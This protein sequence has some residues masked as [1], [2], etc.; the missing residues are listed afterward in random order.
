MFRLKFQIFKFSPENNRNTLYHASAYFF[1]YKSLRHKSSIQTFSH[2]LES[3]WGHFFNPFRK[4]I[5]WNI[6]TSKE[7]IQ[8]CSPA[9]LINPLVL[10]L[11]SP[12]TW[13]RPLHFLNRST[14]HTLEKWKAGFLTVYICYLKILKFWFNYNNFW[15]FAIIEVQL[16]LF[17][18]SSTSNTRDILHDWC[19]H[20]GSSTSKLTFISENPKIFSIF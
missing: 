8:D 7:F 20:G 10:S 13:K 5:R 9:K 18:I 15:G 2:R 4:V 1:L 19:C 14:F 11:I 16:A 12:C 17:K 3:K 6:H